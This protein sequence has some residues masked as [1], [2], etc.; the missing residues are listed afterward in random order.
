MKLFQID[1]SVFKDGWLKKYLLI[2]RLIC[3]LIFVFTLQ[4]SASV[5]SQ[6]TMSVKLKN[7]TL[8]EL[9]DQI[10]KNSN[11][12]FFYNNDEV[13]V[14]QQVSV[15]MEE[16]TVDKILA[17]ALRGTPYSFKEMN[18]KL[19]LIE[20][21]TKPAEV[22]TQQQRSVSGK[23]TDSGKNPIPGVSVAVKG[24]TNGTITDADGNYTLKKVSPNEVLVFSFVGMKS[25]EVSIKDNSTI[26]VTLEEEAIGLEEVVA[27]GYG[28]ARKQ[29]LSGAVST[30]KVNDVM[31]SSGTSLGNILQGQLPG[32]T[33]ASTG[34][35]PAQDNNVTI[36]GL[37]NRNGDAILTV[38]DGIPDAVYNLEDVESVTILKD[39]ATAAIY[40][41]TAGSGGVILI[42]TKKAKSG[43]IKV[44][45]NV[46]TGVQTAWKK[47]KVLNSAQYDQVWTDA[48]TAYGDLV[49]ND[50]ADPSIFPYGEVTRT[51]WLDEVFRSGKINHVAVSLT[52]GSDS[53]KGLFSATYDKQ[54]GIMLNTF[55]ESFSGRMQ[56]D[57]SLAKNL[58]FTENVVYN[59]SNY[60]GNVTNNTHNGQLEASL[61]YPTSAT[62]YEYDED[63]NLLYNDD[64]TPEYGGTIPKWAVSE[65]GIS[66]YA[67]VKNPVAYLRRL[68]QYNPSQK[69]HSTSSLEFKPIRNLNIKSDFS[70]DFNPEYTTSFTPKF[71]EYGLTSTTNYRTVG[72][73]WNYGWSWQT[74]A[75]YTNTFAQKHDV[76]IMLGHTM[77][78]N[79]YR[80]NA[81]YTRGYSSEDEYQRIETNASDWTSDQPTESISE[82]SSM[83]V[84]GRVSYSY[85]DRYFLTSSLRR[86]AT[87]KLYKDNNSGTFPA[88]SAAWKA[89]SESFFKA[90][91][92]PVSFLKVRGSWGQV[93]N[94]SMV[95]NYSYNSS[96]LNGKT[97]SST[98]LGTDHTVTYGQY[99]S[100]IANTNLKWETTETTDLGLDISFLN[101]N[102]NFTAD[103]YNKNTKNLIEEEVI[104]VQAGISTAPYGN[105]G[106]VTNKGF[107]I[108]ANYKQKIGNVD[109]SVYG[110][111]CFNKNEVKS[112]GD[113]SYI[114]SDSPLRSTVGQPWYSF[115]II[116][117]AGIFQTQ[118]QINSYT[119]D[120]SLI[121]PSAK[122]G[123]L[124]YVDYNGDGK[125]TEDDRQYCGSNAPKGTYGFGTSVAWKG[126][127][128]SVFFQGVW[129][130]KIYSQVKQWNLNGGYTSTVGNL[131]TDVLKSWDYDKN[132]GYPR[133]SIEEDANGNYSTNSDFFLES[134]AYIRLKTLSFGYTLPKSVLT[135]IGVPTSHIR[136]YVNAQNLLTFT[137]YKTGFD[138]EVANKGIDGGNYPVARQ[139]CGG[140]SFNF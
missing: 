24:T 42:T 116:K 16:K 87:S 137:A 123:D 57:F 26:N 139:I 93:G 6:T 44:D 1:L 75:N 86:D 71:P 59:Y 138:P 135:K 118:D 94:V 67:N 70:G 91:G 41:A 133:L 61:L 98:P 140:L 39:G 117:T 72:S 68:D 74:V 66:G 106:K 97:S 76:T 84:F 104:P 60:Q 120:G 4:I 77:S 5:W 2:M 32:L 121:Q 69:I 10:E 114:D 21:Q 90:L 9:F 34:G 129:G 47:L 52:G 73:S 56:L 50:V 29:D 130:N 127:D 92:L 102:L 11:Y 81:T 15:D 45:A 51:N 134:G 18:N 37:G 108:S 64:G 33:V 27:I 3:L 43:K 35:D 131:L 79:K 54:E 125:I 89:S 46:Y 31:K 23:V 48:K 111:I 119:K 19:I 14:N 85:D 22:G 7:S 58:T 8:Q 36:R 17:K 96:I 28:N 83:S 105:V 95:P 107:E 136:L 126:F 55:K 112:L 122:P 113:L 49:S 78:Y 25:K 12:R 65:L 30:T 38:V 40:G 103:Y 110:N 109:V 128:L 101:N 82:L 100:T 13:D 80:S 99:L 62:V 53:M 63:G 115:Y 132:S 20:K 124:I 88:F